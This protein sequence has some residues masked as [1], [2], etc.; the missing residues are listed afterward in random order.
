[1]PAIAQ[2]TAVWKNLKEF[3]LEPI[4]KEA[5][6]PLKIALVGAQGSGRH[7]LA[8][9]CHDINRSH[10]AAATLRA[11]EVWCKPPVD[12]HAGRLTRG[13]AI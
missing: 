2:L 3:E 12:P 11:G 4:R 13:E 10:T 6:R 9:S 7:R 5:L 1:M 8:D